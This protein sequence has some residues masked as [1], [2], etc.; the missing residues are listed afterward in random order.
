V[1][2]TTAIAALMVAL[3]LACS[4]GSDLIVANTTSDT[5]S[6]RAVFA[7]NLERAGNLPI[8]FAEIRVM[9]SYDAWKPA[10]QS[11]VTVDP[12]GRGVFVTVPPRTAARIGSVS[13]CS[14]PVPC[15]GFSLTSIELSGT[16]GS[17][18]IV[19]EGK[20]RESFATENAYR[21]VLWYPL[22]GVHGFWTNLHIAQAVRLCLA[23]VVAAFTLWTAVLMTRTEMPRRWGWAAIALLGIGRFSINWTTGQTTESF[24]SFPVLIASI[25]RG[26]ALSPWIVAFSFPLGAIVALL[27]RQYVLRTPRTAPGLG[28]ESSAADE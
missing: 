26:D 23:F 15:R 4:W 13:N 11:T 25:G 2:R 18:R 24:L 1:K 27:R 3:C 22:T 14:D 5:L 19:E 10:P 12:G 7:H 28:P 9:G 20:L 21:W 16:S 6:V 17:I 8:R